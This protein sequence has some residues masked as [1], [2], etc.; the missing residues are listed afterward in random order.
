MYMYMD[1]HITCR[2]SGFLVLSLP[3]PLTPPLSS[4]P[5]PPIHPPPN[6]TFPLQRHSSSLP[7]PPIHTHTHTHT[8]TTHTP[9]WCHEGCKES[10]LGGREEIRA[11]NSLPHT[12]KVQNSSNTKRL[13]RNSNVIICYKIITHNTCSRSLLNHL[14]LSPCPHPFLLPLLSFL[15]S[16]RPLQ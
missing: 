15:P 1:M 6:H 7:L 11:P 8:H 9:L 10:L 3:S 2:V 5:L 12:Q 13:Q 16:R 4:R 14:F